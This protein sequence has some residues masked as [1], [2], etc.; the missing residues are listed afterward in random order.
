[1]KKKLLGLLCACLL[2]SGC[3]NNS[4]SPVQTAPSTTENSPTASHVPLLEQGIA[5]EESSNLLYI[6]N[7][8][9]ESMNAPEV[10]LM[11]NGL[12]LSGYSKNE[13]VL[14]R[15]SLEDG[16]LVKEC[17]VPAC[18]GTKLYIG[19]GEIG[20]CD[21]EL[22]LIS[23]L[24]EDFHLQR[25]YD[26]PNEGDDWYLN[27]ELDTLYVFYFDRGLLARNL[28]TGESHWLVDNSFRV[29]PVGGGAGYVLFTYT[30]RSDQKTYTKCLNLST[31]TMET[32]PI[33]DAVSG[34]ARQGEVWLLH[35]SNL[36]GIHFLVQGE[37]VCSFA[38]TDSAV[39]FLSPRRH[40][41]VTDSPG[42]N[43]TLYETDGTLV[44]RCALPQSSNAVVG[45][46]LVW[47][48]YWEGYFFTDF[49][50]SS[51]RL[52]F[53]DISAAAEGENLQTTPLEQTQPSQAVL[54]QH[55]YERA[56]KMSQRFGVDIRIAEQC[57]LDYSHYSTYALTDPVFVHSALDILEESLKMYP[58]GFFQQLL[59]G[60]V[61]SIR[62]QLVGS[63]SAKPGVVTHPSSVGA[64][65]QNMGSYYTIV[66]NGF[67]LRQQ[68]VFHEIAHVINA[69]LEWDAFIREDALYSEEA[70][71]ALQPEGFQYAMS[72]T[73][74]SEE[75]LKYME[76]DY[77][78]SDSSLTF[79]AEDRAVLLSAAMENYG[80]AFE[81]GTGRWEK[82]RFYAN[83]I[84][85]CFN[86]D[87]WQEMPSWEK[88]LN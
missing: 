73:Q 6:P 22:R 5:M 16:T 41:L 85:D 11:G 43:L 10:S 75:Q 27:S 40:L 60:S 31:A 83:C 25:T 63:L 39:R 38:W 67:L 28:E 72:Y 46:D 49:I 58:E 44:S 18:P 55:L 64:F 87:G 13:F 23:V 12:L 21:R 61:K 78:I 30:D 86:T 80:W 65:A 29:T 1:M 2:L 20:L 26:V 17:S 4:A 42:R 62:I 79:P 50:E 32:L 81:V 7:A 71:M 59:Y 8:T 15:I 56:E 54:E 36:D 35:S 33:E 66:L 82:L 69:R 9:V 51:W 57:T 45:T 70:W 68:T 24:N 77:F 37:S 48:D 74:I 53:W 76:S 14:K 52:L 3:E 19:S 84:R 47:C 34:G 88:Y